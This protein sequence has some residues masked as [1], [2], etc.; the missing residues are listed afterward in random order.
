[1]KGLLRL[2]AAT[3]LV[4]AAEGRAR[5]EQVHFDYVWHSGRLEAGQPGGVRLR[6]GPV[7]A[8]MHT[9][10][11]QRG[12]APAP[13][14]DIG[15]LLVETP[16]G[17]APLFLDEPFSVNY[18]FYEGGGHH[19]RLTVAGRLRGTLGPGPSTMTLTFSGPG[20]VRL[21]D[22]LYQV[23]IDPVSVP[24]APTRTIVIVSPRL[25]VSEA[26]H[27]PEPSALALAAAAGLTLA[28]FRRFRPPAAPR[29]A[30][31]PSASP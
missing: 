21:G 22:H 15:P 13:L 27:A 31:R 1:M 12:A 7:P 20:S 10:S 8:V 3:A 2:C 4:L 14:G 23:W 26:P 17:A 5:A 11:A 25:A 6:T 18:T 24:P 16:P 28:A 30:R 19:G 9:G 29:R